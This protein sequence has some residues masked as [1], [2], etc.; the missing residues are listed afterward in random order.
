M[1]KSSKPGGRPRAAGLFRAPA[2]A[3]GLLGQALRWRPFGPLAIPA[4]KRLTQSPNKPY[5]VARA[6]LPIYG[7]TGFYT[8]PKP[9]KRATIKEY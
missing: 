2:S 9:V 4:A 1:K 6:F 8:A 5:T 7:T 3:Y